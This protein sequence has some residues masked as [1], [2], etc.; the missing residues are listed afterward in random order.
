MAE[1]NVKG[2]ISHLTDYDIPFKCPESPDWDKHCTPYNLR[3][4]VVPTIVVFPTATDHI[5]KAV[6]LASRWG[7]KVQARS[8]GHSYGSY[9]NCGMVVNLKN[10][11]SICV[12]YKKAGT[13]MVLRVCVDGGVRLGNLAH[14]I[15]DYP[16]SESWDHRLGKDLALPHGTCAGVG[17]GGHITHG[18]F[19]FFSRAWGLAMDRVVAM[20]VI[21][22]DGACV[23]V[24]KADNRDLFYA[25]RGAGDS[26]GIVKTFHLE[27]VSAP[28]SVLCWEMKI[29]GATDTVKSAVKTFEHIQTV[30]HNGT[31]VDGRLGLNV[32]VTATF[33]GLSGTY[34]GDRL[35]FDMIIAA[36][37]AGFQDQPE[38]NIKELGWLE[39][40]KYLN[41]DRDIVLPADHKEH[42]N[43]FAKSVVAPAPGYTTESLTDFFTYLFANGKPAPISHYILIDLYGGAGSAIS[44]Q[45]MYHSPFGHR[46]ATWIAQIQGVVDNDQEFPQEGLDFVNGLANAMTA[47]L[48]RSGAYSNYLDPSLS[49]EEAN[50]LYYGEK[51]YEILKF[52]KKKWDPKNVFANPQSIE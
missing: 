47:R 20:D 32:N 35:R 46:D 4:P 1:K 29:N 26:F 18:G 37:A 39:A 13:A 21:T 16:Y 52:L 28:E 23:A 51:I 38:I 5:C 42:S 43:F 11:Q 22:A 36:L 48:P 31:L 40:V 6:S 27:P 8:G 45:D 33:M 10:F 34:L 30:I 2:L 7:I 19:G 15:I 3:L 25:M 49:R 9:S 12:D 50:R 14:A 17:V 24:N 41:Q 44:Q